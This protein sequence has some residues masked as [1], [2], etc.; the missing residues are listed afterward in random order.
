MRDQLFQPVFAFDNDRKPLD[1]K[2]WR[3]IEK[4]ELRAVSEATMA[5]LTISHRL[6]RKYSRADGDGPKPTWVNQTI[7]GVN[8]FVYRDTPGEAPSEEY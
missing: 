2:R 5:R 3:L 8:Q 1:Q 6:S 4:A 7:K